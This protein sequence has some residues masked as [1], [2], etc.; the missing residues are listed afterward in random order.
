MSKF[1]KLVAIVFIV[2]MLVLL[3]LP[4]LAAVSTN[5]DSEGLGTTAEA[6]SIPGATYSGGGAWQ[7]VDWSAT[8]LAFSGY[9]L[10]SPFC[11]TVLTIDFDTQQA[12]A[13]F[14]WASASG[15]LGVNVYYGGGLV[16]SLS[17]NTVSSFGDGS[18]TASISGVFDQLVIDD[19]A[20]GG[21]AGIDDLV[22]TDAAV[23]AV[24]PAT[25]DDT[26]Q[27]VFFDDRI[28]SYDTGNSVVLY[29]KPD[30]DDN[31][32]LE[33]YNADETGLLLVVY[34]ETIAAV[35]ECPDTNTLI[36]NDE[37][38]GISLWRLPER[39]ITAEGVRICPFQLNAPSTEAGKTY[40]IIFDS[41]YPSS[42]YESE[43]EWIGQ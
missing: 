6:L 30:A 41:L 19:L 36:I 35:P 11:G 7:I 39:T 9:Q 24:P 31:W 29:G 1:Y 8:F 16:S 23:G 27:Q 42:Y 43:D 32:R 2:S 4:V 10:L 40:V 26:P 14:D 33:V 12:S 34:P 37:A 20:G 25:I 38:T 28:N 13:N 3:A 17:F 22:T 5:F 18:G 15:Q 21:C